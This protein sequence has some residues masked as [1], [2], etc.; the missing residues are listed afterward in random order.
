MAFSKINKF[1]LGRCMLQWATFHKTL[2]DGG[3][4]LPLSSPLSPPPLS[5][6][7]CS[8]IKGLLCSG[9]LRATPVWPFGQKQ[10]KGPELLGTTQQAKKKHQ[11]TRA[12]KRHGQGP[13]PGL[14]ASTSSLESTDSCISFLG[15][16]RQGLKHIMQLRVTSPSG[17]RVWTVDVTLL[18]LCVT[19]VLME[20][21]P[22][23]ETLPMALLTVTK[24]LVKV[25]L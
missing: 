25:A 10:V 22:K 6:P 13:S 5:Q 17:L 19:L 1:Y 18:I 2:L 9:V 23:L 15:F 11:R 7:L 24:A 20:S 21:C 12:G 14:G 8:Q 4:S 3:G 16:L